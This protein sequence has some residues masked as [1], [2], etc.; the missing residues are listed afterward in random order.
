MRVV[1]SIALRLT[2]AVLD[3]AATQLERSGDEA[4][5]PVDEVEACPEIGH[6]VDIDPI[7][8]WPERRPSCTH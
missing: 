1:V 8:P 5:E 2:A 6:I 3:L 4:P 7:F